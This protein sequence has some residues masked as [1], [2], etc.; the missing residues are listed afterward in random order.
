[1]TVDSVDF[2]PQSFDLGQGNFTPLLMQVAGNGT[3]VIVVAQNVPAVL[4]LDLNAGTTTAIP[5][6]NNPVPLAAAASTDGSQVFVAACDGIHPD[7]PDT[8]NSVHLVNTLAGGDIQEVVFTNT[9]TSDSMCNNLPGIPCLPNL[10]AIKP[11]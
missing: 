11:Q 1:V 5:L 9:N 3:Q 10:I 6:A 2:P 8:C 7:H 4:V